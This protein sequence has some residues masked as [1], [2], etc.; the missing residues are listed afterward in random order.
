MEEPI[1]LVLL[2]T[3]HCHLCEEAAQ[4]LK[5]ALQSKEICNMHITTSYID[6]IDDDT[7][8][9]EYSLEIPVITAQKGEKLSALRWPFQQAEVI[10]FIKRQTNKNP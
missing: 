3:S 8:Y 2:G 4:H 1:N 10:L 9:A 6:I 5:E 7:L